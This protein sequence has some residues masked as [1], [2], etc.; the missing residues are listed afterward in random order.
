M[1]LTWLKKFIQNCYVMLCSTRDNIHK[2][3]KV[4]LIEFQAFKNNLDT[5][6]IKELC[7]GDLD[8]ENYCR[9]LFKPPYKK[10]LLYPKVRTTNDWLERNWHRI[11]WYE[12]DVDY[13]NLRSILR[14]EV[15]SH[16]ILITKGREKAVFLE[17]ILERNVI[18]AED[19]LPSSIS[20]NDIRDGDIQCT[21]TGKC[22]VKNVFKLR[23]WIK[24]EPDYIKIF[25]HEVLG[26]EINK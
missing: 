17:K 16:S 15:N 20:L 11:G 5:Y 10:C 22:A 19:L 18:N 21:H 3:L 12:G 9:Y 23:E 14:H 25:Q 24:S 8:S 13:C 4:L 26:F 6:I 2:M 1:K 7:C